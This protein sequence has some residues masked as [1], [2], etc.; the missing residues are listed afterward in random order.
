LKGTA[1]TRIA[2]PLVLILLS[3]APAVADIVS[4]SQTLTYENNDPNDPNGPFFIAREC[5]LD[6]PP[7][8]RSMWEDWG[9]THDM[10]ALKPLD[11]NGILSGTLTIRTWDV[12][13][14]DVDEP[15]VDV[16]YA[17]E[18]RQPEGQRRPNV[19]F[20]TWNGVTF[21]PAT[22]IGALQA[23]NVYFWGTTSLVVPADV[24]GDLWQQGKVN[25][26]MDI[27]SKGYGRRVTLAYATLTVDYIV[28]HSTW[29]PDM[30]VYQF[31]SPILGRQFRT[32]KE[33]ENSQLPAYDPNVWIYEGIAFYTY[34]DKRND[35][36]SPVYCFWSPATSGCFYT[37]KE[38]EKNN[39]MGDGTLVEGIPAMWMYEGIAF[40]AHPQGRQPKDARPV[41]RF[42]SDSLGRYAYASSETER[43]EYV[44]Q[45]GIWRDEGIAWYAY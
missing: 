35:T 34:P 24:L 21:M 39:L 41:Y 3:G 29:Q 44:N 23:T 28:P 12:D 5:V 10:K 45:P 43:Q 6:H 8:Y 9:W 19:Y 32:A 27:D 37:I 14:C 15:E 17:I 42:W 2:L 18:P 36:V 20:H 22:Q 7:C 1:V 33:S 26:F 11:A 31:W 38:N 30:P 25:F 13:A 40:Y 16:I 4:V